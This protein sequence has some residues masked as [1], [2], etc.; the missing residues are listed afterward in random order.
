MKKDEIPQDD[1][2][3]A[4]HFRELCYAKDDNGNYTTGLS[5]GWEVKNVALDQAW[6]EIHT[7]IR[8]T[9]MLIKQGKKTPLAYFMEVS[10]MDSKLLS[11]YI[12]KFHFVVKRHLN[13]P[14]AF[15]KLSD[16]E[17]IKYARIFDVSLEDLKFFKL[18]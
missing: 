5:T 13:K 12:G 11:Q 9:A 2:A 10:L 16:P 1:G 15:S 17:L 4:N 18:A 6:D 3:L 8:E 14:S 7:R